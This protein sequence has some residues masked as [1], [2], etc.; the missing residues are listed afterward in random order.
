MDN[1]LAKLALTKDEEAILKQITKN[2]KNKRII[3]IETG[4]VFSSRKDLMQ[5]L[6]VAESTVCHYFKGTQKTLKGKTY[7]ELKQ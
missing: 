7:K 6:N 1:L 5:K 4:E 3:C 2:S